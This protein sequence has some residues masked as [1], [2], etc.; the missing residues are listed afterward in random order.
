VFWQR[1]TRLGKQLLKRLL[2]VGGAVGLTLVFFLVLPLMQQIARTPTDQMVVRSVDTASIPPPP[3]PPQEEPEEP[4]EP[5]EQPELEEQSQPLDLSQLELAL[6]PGSGG[7]LG[8]G[9]LEV[10]LSGVADGG[11][12]IESLFNMSQLD[13]K[14]RPVY[15]P[16]PN[17]TERMR[18]RAPGTVYVI[19]IVNEQGRVEEAR[20]QKASDPVFTQPALAAV[21]KWRFEPGKR[22]GEPVPFR[23]VVPITFPEI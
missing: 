22:N 20:I 17:I 16:S 4:E 9:T 2:V 10:D 14:P 8:A 11:S 3:E 1:V 7:G 18:R 23:M 13:Q 19:F 6:N 12:D 5:E 21:K 15:Q